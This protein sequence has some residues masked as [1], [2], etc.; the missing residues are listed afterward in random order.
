KLGWGGIRDI[1]FIVQLLQLEL[2]GRDPHVRTP[3]TLDALSRLERTGVLTE[4]EASEL[5]EDYCFLRTV[6]HR[7]Q[8]LYE[9]QTQTLPTDPSE[10]RLLARRL[11]FAD[12]GAID[13]EYR[14]RTRRVR[15]HF[16]RLFLAG[17]REDAADRWSALFVA[18]SAEARDEVVGRLREAG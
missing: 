16:E 6:E 5:S 3:N 14:R 7:L 18:D 1:E 12:A 11:G 9:L 10:R 15:G 8:I 13:E 17:K 4:E 2:G